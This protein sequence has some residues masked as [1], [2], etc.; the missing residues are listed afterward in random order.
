[1]K[2]CQKIAAYIRN[3]ILREV[4]PG[5]GADAVFA[6]HLGVSEVE[7]TAIREGLAQDVSEGFLARFADLAFSHL[8]TGD[9][10]RARLS[11]ASEWASRGDPADRAAR[12]GARRAFDVLRRAHG[13]RISLKDLAGIAQLPRDESPA[14]MVTDGF[15]PRDLLRLV[16]SIEDLGARKVADSGSGIN[17]L[18]VAERGRSS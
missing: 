17:A 3:W 2:H 1:M 8:G 15:D 7:V 5:D 10:R 12:E 18:F 11:I 9:E 14:H 16:V 6:Q 13:E 4:Q